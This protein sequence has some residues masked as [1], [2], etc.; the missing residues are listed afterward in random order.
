M[1]KSRQRSGFTIIE[2]LVVI[3]IFLVM[4]AALTPA[5]KMVRAHALR[6]ECLNHLR[7]VSLGIH[8]YAAGHNGSFPANL[9]ELH[10][11]YAANES[12]FDCPASKTIGTK[13]KPDYAYKPG[14]TETSS[15]RETIVE[16]IGG[17]HGK[18]G[19]NIL[20]LDGSLDWVGR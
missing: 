18:A 7:Q 14:L 17:N 5:V 12:A 4:I 9:S 13:E 8:A 2:V 16:D 15:P 3:A 11:Q 19:K 1:M 6:R 10:P 20:R